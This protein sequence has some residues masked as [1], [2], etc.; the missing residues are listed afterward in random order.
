MSAVPE[1]AAIYEPKLD[2]FV[3]IAHKYIRNPWSPMIIWMQR[4]TWDSLANHA[5]R[6]GEFYIPYL[7][8]MVALRTLV[9]EMEKPHDKDGARPLQYHGASGNCGDTE[10]QSLHSAEQPA[11]R[12][13]A[14]HQENGDEV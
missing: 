10:R 9:A 7:Q 1:I 8:G 12:A 2:G 13:L 4:S 3:S 6:D 5:T 11:N 14:R